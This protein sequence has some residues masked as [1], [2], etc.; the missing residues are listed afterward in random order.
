M[1]DFAQQLNLWIEGMILGLGYPGI[2]LV[3]FVENLFPPIPSE[4]IL[5]YAGY[6]VS[7]GRFSLVG[8]VAAAVLGSLL[9]AAALYGLGRWLEDHMLH[10]A[11]SRYGRYFGV[12][13]AGWERALRLFDRHGVGAVCFA[14]VIPLVRSLVSLP[15]G[16]DHMP[17]RKFFLATVIGVAVWS[18]TLTLA[19]LGL[20]E[21][22]ETLLPMVARYEKAVLLAVGLG[23]LAWLARRLRARSRAQPATTAQP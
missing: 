6:Q 7:Q 21:S 19:G 9:G 12:S 13:E 11:I 15:A 20:G 1:S 10:R 16:M 8:V 18:L 3:M 5:P 2:V 23:A 22:W 14:R 4:L 17:W